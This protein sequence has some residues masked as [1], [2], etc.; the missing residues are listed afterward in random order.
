MN[1]QIEWRLLRKQLI[2]LFFMV[3]ETVGCIVGGLYYQEEMTTQV[4]AMRQRLRTLLDKKR[5]LEEQT[6]LLGQYKPSFDAYQVRGVL[7]PEEPRLRWVEHILSVEKALDLPMP[8]RFKLDVRKPF[9]PPL[10]L[11]KTHR[12]AL[13]QQ[14]GGE[15]WTVARRGFT[16]FFQAA[17]RPWLRCLRCKNLQDGAG[18]H[19]VGG[20]GCLESGA[21]CQCGLPDQL[22]LV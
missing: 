11:A 4:E 12:Q 8:L 2:I 16:L 14:H 5:A 9:T 19:P 21:P 18:E 1:S 15:P 13:C 7:D 6:R 20:A 3:F 17:C 22:V 10:P